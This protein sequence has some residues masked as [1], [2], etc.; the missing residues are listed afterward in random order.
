MSRITNI[1]D[2]MAAELA[3]GEFSMEFAPTRSV[4]PKFTPEEL[5]SA[6][7]TVIPKSSSSEMASRATAQ[8]DLAIDIAVQ[9]K[10]E[11]DQE[12]EVADL[13]GLVDEIDDYLRGRIL[14]KVPSAQWL[15]SANEPVYS[16]AH[17][18]EHRVFTGVLTI[19]YRQT[20]MR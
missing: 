17:L 9:K 1:A 10:I 7:V 19:T 20:I 6:C 5:A 11:K 18:Q 8:Y 13:C 4:W 15:N 12:A 3:R 14:E 16:A 2:A